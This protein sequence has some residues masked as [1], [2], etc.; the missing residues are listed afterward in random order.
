MLPTSIKNITRLLQLFIPICQ[1]ANRFWIDDF[2]FFDFQD[3]I[4]IEWLMLRLRILRPFATSN[5]YQKNFIE[6]FYLRSKF[7]NQKSQLVEDIG[8]EPMTLSLQS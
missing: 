6:I 8:V 1:R 4:L 2:G 5:A 7:T 3:P